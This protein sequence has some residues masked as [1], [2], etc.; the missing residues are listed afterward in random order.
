MPNKGT[1][2]DAGEGHATADFYDI[3]APFYHLIYPDWE[4]SIERQGAAIDRVIGELLPD[5]ETLLD[6]SCGIGT[7]ALGLAER[8]YRV[9]A[10]DLS[11]AAVQRARREARARRL[12]MALSVADMRA[13]H[14][15]PA[16][17]FDVVLC[18]D[19]ALPHLLSDGDIAEALRSFH[20]AL[21]PGGLC[22]ASVRDYEREDLSGTRLVPHGM[23]DADGARWLLWQVWEPRGRLY[24]FSLYLVEDRGRDQCRTRVVRS[25]YYAVGA[26]RLV[27]LMEEAGF[28]EV[29]RLDDRF[30]QPLIVGLKQGEKHG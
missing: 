26:D 21:R 4:K 23:R 15:H 5:A 22:L 13:A 27:A 12:D 19:N 3:L 6:V 7:Q 2:S 8:G 1:D 20:R 14:G 10:S 17:P 30:F 11:P 28:A 18:G 29:R 16:A 25:T 9:S 24:D